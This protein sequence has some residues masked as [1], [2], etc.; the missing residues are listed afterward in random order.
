MPG[1]I[2]I[3]DDDDISD[4]ARTLAIV[5]MGVGNSFRYIFNYMPSFRISNN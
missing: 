5:F 2:P 4:L 3:Y 1:C